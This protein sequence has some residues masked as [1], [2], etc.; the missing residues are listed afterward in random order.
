MIKITLN[1][2][3]SNAGAQYELTSPLPL[4]KNIFDIELL[5]VQD[6]LQLN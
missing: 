6:M 4:K 1:Q 3:E 2:L 5:H